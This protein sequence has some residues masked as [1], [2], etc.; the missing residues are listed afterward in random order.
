MHG[1][2]HCFSFSHFIRQERGPT[3]KLAKRFTH[4]EHF[5][6]VQKFTRHKLSNYFILPT[7]FYSHENRSLYHWMYIGIFFSLV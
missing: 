2:P 3:V 5:I 7:R 4:T 6:A 1:F